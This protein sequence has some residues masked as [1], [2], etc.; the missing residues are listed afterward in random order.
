VIYSN[1]ILL[2]LLFLLKKNHPKNVMPPH[3]KHFHRDNTEEKAQLN[4]VDNDD[5]NIFGSFCD[6]FSML[7]RRI[8]SL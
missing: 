5:T 7:L 3:R 6:D 4:R 8:W 2:L 1:C